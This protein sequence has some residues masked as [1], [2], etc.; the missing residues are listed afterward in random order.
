VLLDLGRQKHFSAALEV[1]QKL[2]HLHDGMKVFVTRCVLLSYHIQQGPNYLTNCLQAFW[3]LNIS[4]RRKA[5]QKLLNQLPH[6]G[7]FYRFVKVRLLLITDR[8]V[9]NS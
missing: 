9:V 2:R 8:F 4:G 3:F 1:K 7:K 5:N 6:L